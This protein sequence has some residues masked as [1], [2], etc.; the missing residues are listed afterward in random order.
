MM[1]EKGVVQDRVLVFLHAH[2]VRLNHLI[3]APLIRHAFIEVRFV[4][5]ADIKGLPEVIFSRSLRGCENSQI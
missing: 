2:H 1:D 4:V 3:I 5:R